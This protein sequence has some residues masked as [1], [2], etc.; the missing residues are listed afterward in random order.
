MADEI[1][2]LA[3]DRLIAAWGEPD[4]A[5]RTLLG[6]EARLLH[7]AA[8]AALT[9]PTDASM[10]HSACQGVVVH[11]ELFVMWGIS[12]EADERLR[13]F[14]ARAAD[15]A[16]QVPEPLEV[17]RAVL[18]VPLDHAGGHVTRPQAPMPA[19]TVTPAP[20]AA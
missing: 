1:E 17:L 20:H 2:A 7:M 15:E 12:Q 4:E 19:P 5:E 3:S 9:H 13:A 14:A 6:H 8:D 10:V 16:G 18:G 11:C